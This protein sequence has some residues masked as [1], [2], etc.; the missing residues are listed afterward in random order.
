[1]RLGFDMT[2]LKEPNSENTQSKQTKQV[3]DVKILIREFVF[4]FDVKRDRL[5]FVRFSR[6]REWI[7]DII[8]D[9]WKGP[10]FL[11]DWILQWGIGDPLLW[12]TWTRDG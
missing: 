8:R 2:W 9:A 12:R 3:D 5:D 11:R 10:I 6:E 7:L 1:M 4:Y